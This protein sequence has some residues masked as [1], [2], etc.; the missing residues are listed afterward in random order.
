MLR[1][2]DA[3]VF[4][5]LLADEVADEARGVGEGQPARQRGAEGFWLS[6]SLVRWGFDTVMAQFWAGGVMKVGCL[7]RKVF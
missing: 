3:K 4:K 7:I 5:K 2:G 1:Q 6:P